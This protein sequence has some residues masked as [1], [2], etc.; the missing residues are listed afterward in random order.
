MFEK[1]ITSENKESRITQVVM[2]DFC[3]ILKNIYLSI[4]K[5]S[6]IVVRRKYLNRVVCL[7]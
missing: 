1:Q 7:Q 4:K 5:L 6:F 2:R 3:I